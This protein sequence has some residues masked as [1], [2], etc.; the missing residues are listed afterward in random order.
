MERDRP[1][2]D[3][4][5]ETAGLVSP[6][7]SERPVSAELKPPAVSAVDIELSAA[8]NAVEAASLAAAVP[9]D[10]LA[11]ARVAGHGKYS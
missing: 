7:E 11:V 6:M 1:N 3:V 8:V 5:A 10:E 9:C 2:R 4:A